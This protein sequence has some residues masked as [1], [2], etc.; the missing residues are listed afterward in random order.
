MRYDTVM[1]RVPATL[2]LFGLATAVTAWAADPLR[3]YFIDVEGGQATLVVSPSGES[4]LIDTGY[5][6]YGGRDSVRIAKAAKDAGVKR[7]DTLLITHFHDD[8]VGGVEN[9]VEQMPVVTFLDH[10]PSIETGSY[11]PA[12]AKAF[13]EA[14]H[15]VVKPGDKIPVKDL[16][17]TVVASAGKTITAGGDGEENLHCAGLEPK[18]EPKPEPKDD[19]K[20][21]E[22]GENPQSVAIVVG[23][24]NFRF[25]DFGDLGWN[26]ELS[27]MCPTNK[28]GQVDL[29]LAT[30]HGGESPRAIWDLKPRVVVMN[31]GPRKGDDP[32]GWKNVMASP[33]LVDLWQLHFA[34]ANGS[35]ANAPDAFIANLAENGKGEHLKVEVEKDGSFTV[36]NPRNKYT[37]AYA[38][39]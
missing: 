5:D 15:Q 28:V 7:I 3:I 27:L 36:T 11:P 12:Y 39:R 30:H 10:G 25:A 35:E 33:G 21:G 4:L 1:R 32:E 38:A 17:I 34:M 6:R 16:D 23:Y 8:H 13:A 26:G 24:R 29:F 14:K 37:R 9:L 2:L 18:L 20:G 19:T 22:Q 31:N